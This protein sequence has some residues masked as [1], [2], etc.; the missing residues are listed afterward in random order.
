M[1]RSHSATGAA[2]VVAM[3]RREQPALHPPVD[4][5]DAVSGASSPGVENVSDAL[6]GR[7]EPKCDDESMDDV[8]VIVIEDDPVPQPSPT[9]SAVRRQEY[10]QLFARLRR[11]S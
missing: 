7:D 5:V 10:R 8:D 3:P 1:S 11:G 4:S 6:R 9:A 2:P